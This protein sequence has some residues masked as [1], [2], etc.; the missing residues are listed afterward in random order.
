LTSR[1]GVNLPELDVKLPSLTEKDLADI[2]FGVSHG[3]D[4]I[5]LSFVR[6]AEDVRLLKWELEKKKASFIPVIAKIEKPQ[7]LTHLE[8]IVSEADG[9]MVARGDLGVEI[10]PERVPVI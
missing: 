10:S 9:I 6:S 7:A 2:A 3:V 8:E 1:K 5:S 4:C